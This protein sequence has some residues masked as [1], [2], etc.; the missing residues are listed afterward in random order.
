MLNGLR[1]GA[2][3]SGSLTQE[4]V[5]HRKNRTFYGKLRRT[6]PAGGS[7]RLDVEFRVALTMLVSHS[8]LNLI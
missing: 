7:I 6:K 5:N 3:S 2:K 1:G 8:N 4:S